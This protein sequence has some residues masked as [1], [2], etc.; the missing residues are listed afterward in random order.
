MNQ[1]KARHILIPTLEEA[2]QLQT[3]ITEGEDFSELAQ[4]YSKCPSGRNGGDLGFFGRG[5]MVRPFDEAVFNLEVGAVS[6]PIQTQFGYHL[7][8][9]TG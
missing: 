5:A 9:R 7:I 4:T 6:S 1:V 3:R 8:Q 2:Q